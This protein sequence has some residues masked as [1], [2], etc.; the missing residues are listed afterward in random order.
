MHLLRSLVMDLWLPE[1]ILNKNDIIEAGEQ[2][3]KVQPSYA[4][5]AIQPALNAFAALRGDGSVVTWG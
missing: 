1:S 2:P 4:L 3:R 5:K